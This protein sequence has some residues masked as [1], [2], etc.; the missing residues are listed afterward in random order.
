VVKLNEMLSK[1]SFICV[2]P[3]H[4]GTWSCFQGLKIFYSKNYLNN[5]ISNV[6]TNQTIPID[7]DFLKTMGVDNIY[8]FTFEQFRLVFALLAIIVLTH[9]VFFMIASYLLT[10]DPFLALR[11]F[12]MLRYNV[13]V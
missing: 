2:Q 7:L 10:G 1:T 5:L 12:Y 13:G 6:I 11:N 8:I 9:A 3:P 4:S